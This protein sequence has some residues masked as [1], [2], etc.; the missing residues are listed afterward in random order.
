MLT[1]TQFFKMAKS[2]EQSLHATPLHY[3]DGN[4]KQC[5]KEIKLICYQEMQI[6]TIRYITTDLQKV[7]GKDVEQSEFSYAAVGI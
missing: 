5:G 1:T 6:Q 2:L 4:L 7:S 3:Q